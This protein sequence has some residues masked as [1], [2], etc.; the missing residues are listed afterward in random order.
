MVYSFFIALLVS[1]GPKKQTVTAQVFAEFPPFAEVPV[2]HQKR[3]LDT[4]FSSSTTQE[5]KEIWTMLLDEQFVT[6]RQDA[7]AILIADTKNSTIATALLGN[8]SAP[9]FERCFVGIQSLLN[10]IDLKTD[11]IPSQTPTPNDKLYCSL[12]YSMQRE[13]FDTFFRVFQQQELPLERTFYQLLTKIPFPKSELATNMK[14]KLL[15]EEDDF[16]FLSLYT[17]WFLLD[18]DAVQSSLIDHLLGADEDDRLEV[19]EILWG[20][21]KGMPIFDALAN[22]EKYSGIFAN[23]AKTAS[24]YEDVSFALTYLQEGKTWELRLVALEA[25]GMWYGKNPRHKKSK[26]VHKELTNL[27]ETEYT[28]VLISLLKGLQSS[29]LTDAIEP[30]QKLNPIDPLAKIERVV[31]LRKLSTQK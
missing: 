18:R 16:G 20:N 5:Q 3:W 8:P 24:G 15:G 25:L 11:F 12:L 14:E 26:Q 28:D 13:N 2:Q 7:I 29:Q 30:I 6:F 21:P 17:T 27:I 4:R 22:T 9:I 1:C 19:L 31:A 23:L 10:K